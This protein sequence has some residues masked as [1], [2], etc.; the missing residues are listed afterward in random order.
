MGNADTSKILSKLK[1]FNDC[2]TGDGLRLSDNQL[3]QV[4]ELVSGNT[5]NL[6][7]KFNLLFQLLKWPIGK[8]NK[9]FFLLF[10][11][12]SNLFR[13]NIPD[14]RYHPFINS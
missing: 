3:Q 8:F 4:H 6:D 2:A 10:F 13:Q 14:I 12:Y 11:S 5:D 1:E 7:A 9:L